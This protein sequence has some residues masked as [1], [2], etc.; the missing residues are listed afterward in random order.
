MTA[1]HPALQA[2]S[3]FSSAA[4]GP[5]QRQRDLLKAVTGDELVRQMV[6]NVKVVASAAA[7]QA[8]KNEKKAGKKQP[9]AAAAK[10]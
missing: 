1:T 7:A 6:G 10:K 4:F 2:I 9:Q 5:T 8:V 3:L